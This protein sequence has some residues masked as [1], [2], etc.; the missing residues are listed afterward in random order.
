M[1]A[2]LNRVGLALADLDDR[3]LGA[4]IA[5]VDDGPQLAPSLFAWI[6]HV[7]D[8]EQ[9]RRRGDGFR[10][11]PPE[12]AIEPGERADAALV[13]ALLRAVFGKDDRGSAAEKL[14]DAMVAVLGPVAT[15]Q[16]RLNA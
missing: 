7:C 3:E 12:E 5:M 15:S 4:L 2:D 8:W 13:L 9:H 16:I 1:S 6:E 10:L 14:L 11:C